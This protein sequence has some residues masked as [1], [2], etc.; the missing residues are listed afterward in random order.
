MIARGG[1]GPWAREVD[2]EELEREL[3]IDA[4]GRALA[5]CADDRPRCSHCRGRGGFPEYDPDGRPL[6]RWEPCDACEGT[7]IGEE[8]P[9]ASIPVCAPITSPSV[10]TDFGVDD[11]PF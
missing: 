1:P 4:R 8:P 6:A 2:H 10:V 3:R 7:G 9:R 11:V 5:R